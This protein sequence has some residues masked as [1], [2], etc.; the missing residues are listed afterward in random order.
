MTQRYSLQHEVVHCHA[1]R[2]FCYRRHGSS[3]CTM[4][5]SGQS[6]TLYPSKVIF[7]PSGILKGP[8]SSLPMIPAQNMT[9]P[10]PSWRHSLVGTLWPSTNHPLLHPSEP[11]R[12][13]RHLSVNKAVWKLVFVYLLA[14]CNGSCLWALVRGGRMVGLCAT[15]SLWRILHLKVCRTLLAP[16]ASNTFLLPCKGILAA[17][18]LIGFIYLAGA[19]LCS[20]SATNLFTI[21]WSC[22]SFCE[23]SNVFIHCPK[24]YTIWRF[25]A[26]KRSFV[27][28][29]LLENCGLVNNGKCPS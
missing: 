10:P 29:I 24:H 21:R 11:S 27:F 6:E 2:W 1:W 5:E 4:E 17:A 8:S 23:I 15:A 14:H 16:A 28:P 22:F 12:V 3:F 9:L 26:A 25:S 19:C 13:A 20:E 7:T 18:L